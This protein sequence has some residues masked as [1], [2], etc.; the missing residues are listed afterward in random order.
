MQ[1]QVREGGMLVLKAVN[2]KAVGAPAIV[3]DQRWANICKVYHTG[4]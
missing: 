4:S 3:S 1:G 2:A